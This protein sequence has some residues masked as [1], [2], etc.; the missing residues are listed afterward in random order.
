MKSC[1]SDAPD[2]IDAVLL[3]RFV[4]VLQNRRAAREKVLDRRLHFA[5]A[6][7][8]YNGLQRMSHRVFNAHHCSIP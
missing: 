3:H 4:T 7:N 6:D 8:I 1:T 2:K 5:H